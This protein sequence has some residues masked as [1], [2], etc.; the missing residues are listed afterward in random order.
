VTRLVDSYYGVFLHRAADSTGESSWVT[1]GQNHFLTF[2]QIGV[3]IVASDEDYMNVVGGGGGFGT[4]N[5]QEV[6]LL[7]MPTQGNQAQIWTGTKGDPNNVAFSSSTVL[8]LGRTVTITNDSTHEIF[9]FFRAA[10]SRPLF[11]ML[12]N[13]NQEYRA[14]VG[15]QLAVQGQPFDYL[16]LLPGEHVTVKIPMVFWDSGRI[17][18]TT[19]PR[20]VTNNNS[21][22]L[23]QIINNPF[24]YYAT[25]N[26]GNP[27]RRYIDDGTRSDTTIVSDPTYKQPPV[28][29]YYHAQ[30]AEGV[31]NAAPAGFIELAI[32]DPAQD[33]IN[34]TNLGP[35][36]LGP[37]VS[38]DV[39]FVDTISLPGALEAPG[40]N[41]PQSI[42]GQYAA[43]QKPFGW[44][45]AP[46]SFTTFQTLVGNFTGNNP[47]NALGNFF[48][49]RGWPQYYVTPVVGS[50]SIIQVPATKNVFEQS[51]LRAVLSPF[52][53][54]PNNSVQHHIMASGG[55]YY[56][57]ATGNV[58]GDG[59]ISSTDLTTI[60]SVDPSVIAQLSVGMEIQNVGSFIFPN[61]TSIK[62]LGTTSIQ[63]TGPSS[64]PSSGGTAFTF[65]GSQFAGTNYSGTMNGTA[66]TLTLDN[67]SGLINLQPGM[68]VTGPG[69]SG[70]GP[71]TNGAVRIASITSGVINLQIQGSATLASGQGPYVFT[72]G[73]SDYAA[74]DLLNLWYAWADFYVSYVTAQSPFTGDIPN[75]T[76]NASNLSSI[77]FTT[78]TQTKN[79]YA[80]MSVTSGV[81]PSGTVITG[82]GTALNPNDRTV[83]NLSKMASAAT[84]DTFTFGLPTQIPR[85]QSL[86]PMDMTLNP[87]Q[88][89]SSSNATQADKD[90]AHAFASVVY[91]VMSAFGG[92]AGNLDSTGAFDSLAFMQNI[93]GGNIAQIP[94]IGDIT[95]PLALYFRDQSKSLERGVADFGAVPS[96]DWYANPALA[97][98]GNLLTGGQ[99]SFNAYSLDPF[100]WFVH[101]YLGVS[102]YAFS[103]DDDAAN[104]TVAGAK[105]LATSVGG[106][107][108]FTNK[109]EWSPGTQFGPVPSA[110]T[111]A[112]L[113]G[114]LTASSSTIS[115][116]P[117]DAFNY[118]SNPA[119]GA[120]NGALVIGP[121]I[122]VSPGLQTLARIM[123]QGVNLSNNEIQLTGG[124]LA[125]GM[126]NYVFFG[127]VH[128]TGSIN[129]TGAPHRITNLNSD[130]IGVLNA[131]IAN[132]T[133]LAALLVSGPGIQPGTSI[134]AIGSDNSIILD[135]AHPLDPNAPVGEFRFTIL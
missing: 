3:G 56:R 31:S 9:P 58:N 26:D 86:V 63:L 96:Y 126:G 70:V 6:P 92:I 73:L 12:D 132:Q 74:Q 84:T 107:S 61:Y 16:G 50:P 89:S 122:S 90:K 98:T 82:F 113:T 23:G 42:T 101:G 102:G 91:S 22:P 135:D 129:P 120:T 111:T 52:Q 112:T 68:L 35:A 93:I 116:I 80:G 65:I 125:D 121:G 11:D 29:F 37:L 119:Q 60:T 118:I 109:A 8:N 134:K 94:K 55:V 115:S 15:Y 14:Y 25:D 59:T 69:I 57:A 100:V 43:I 67:A 21:K 131:I 99:A 81:L 64:Q 49:G 30:V 106:I 114:T 75:G 127:P 51:P 1:A 78:D 117:T 85:T 10:N 104:P 45:G 53:D 46:E 79:L 20:Y 27:T 97:G 7:P 72:G 77:Q 105:T 95:T 17:Y 123:A 19:D 44:V 128:V 5:L 108:S 36:V 32:K 124:Q 48:G 83:V 103:L 76:I 28:M 13:A 110:G 40:A 2:G 38:Y 88:L 133:S 33:Q 24:L 34:G 39:S 4:G 54:G 71:G 87:D 41:V 130:D 62:S 66:K 47:P 18:Y